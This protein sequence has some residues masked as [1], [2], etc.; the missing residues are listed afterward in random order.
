MVKVEANDDL[1]SLM[2][3]IH[4]AEHVAYPQAIKK[5]IKEYL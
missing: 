4:A 3:K 5:I 2:K 1:D